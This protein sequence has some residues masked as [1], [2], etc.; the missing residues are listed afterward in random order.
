[1]SH[2]SQKRNVHCRIAA[3]RLVSLMGK[4]RYTK[5]KK[6]KKKAGY[7]VLNAVL[8]ILFIAIFAAV[9]FY[10][11]FKYDIFRKDP[12]VQKESE[13]TTPSTAQTSASTQK[14]VKTKEVS[15]TLYF[16][17]ANADCVVVEERV[18]KVEEGVQIEKVIFDE[19][20][21]GPQ[22]EGKYPVIPHGSRLL[23]AE[24]KDGICQLDLSTEFVDNNPGGTAF[25]AALINAIV[26]SLTELPQVNKV[27]FLIEGKKRE[28]YTHAEFDKPF[29]RNEGFIKTLDK[30]SEA[31]EAKIRELGNKTLEALRD[32]N[33]QWLSSIIHPDK[34]LRFSPYTYVNHDT[35]LVF[36]ANEILTL[37]SSDKIYNWGRY[38]GSGEAIELNFEEYYSKFVYDK[39]F[40]NAEEV[41]YNRYIGKGNT[42]NNVF[43]IYP[44]GKLMEYYFSGFEP[45]F[46]GLDWESLKLVFEEKDGVW[47]LVGI[48]HD[49]WT[50]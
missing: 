42:L 34:N 50:I 48:V 27:Q 22:G 9:A 10:L 4:N 45:K 40:L 44:D 47:Y 13:I 1:L 7:G 16:P 32:K 5:K 15:L 29:E 36:T 19:M 30:T 26:N 46:E 24:T 35:D 41:A 21:K 31:I 39:D 38:D 14:P 33:M 8:S 3:E 37:L 20:L 11:G 18:I 23:S 6:S 25:E 2:F 49:G 43:D 28:I 17:N 12:E